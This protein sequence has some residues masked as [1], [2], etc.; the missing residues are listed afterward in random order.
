[1]LDR[2][3]RPFVRLVERFYPDPLLFALGLTFVT[4]IMVF[5]YTDASPMQ[6][7]VSWGDGLKVLMAFI[8]QLS[9]TLITSTALAL[10]RP[11]VR[12]LQRLAGL[13]RSVFACYVLTTLVSAL[14]SLVSWALGLVVGGLMARHIQFQAQKKGL[15]LHY[16]LVVAA[17]YSGFV[18]W[19]MGYS[20]SAQLFVATSGHIFEKS[21]GVIPVTQTLFAPYNIIGILICLVSLPLLMALLHPRQEA[22]TGFSDQVMDSVANELITKP[23]GP[24]KT[25]AERF[26]HMR[27]INLLTGVLLIAYL[28]WH[29]ATKGLA[30]DLNIV[31]WS[32]LAL[33]LLLADS[34]IHYVRLVAEAGRN[35]GQIILQ[36]PLYAGLM[37]LMSKSG[38]AKM[39]ATGFAA[40]STKTTL[41]FWTFISAGLLNMFIPSGGGQW[42]I[43]GAVAID[44]AR[45]LDVPIDLLVNAVAYGDQWTNMIQPFWTIPILAIAGLSMRNMMGYTF[46]TLIWTGL[47]FSACLVVLPWLF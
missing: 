18:I 30:L 15:K 21:I 11:V 13:P 25:M 38:L 33:G 27:W 7:V 32:F 14:A 28:A 43:Q 45:S 39:I 5:I 3:S 37:G 31:N 34:P 22:P 24:S 4:F 35:V 9:F 6:A 42:S 36:Y 16:P 8:G 29:F 1:M 20:G 19:H 41:A 47:V 26:E 46:I 17:A 10:T 23:A 40:I 12:L 2:A 44:A